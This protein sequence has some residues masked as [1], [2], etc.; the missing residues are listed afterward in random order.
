[1]AFQQFVIS[2]VNPNNAV[3]GGGCIC[4]SNEQVDCKPPYVVFYGNSMADMQSPH[5]VLCKA[6]L[7]RAQER[8][9]T[10][11][12]LVVGEVEDE[13]VAME[14]RAARNPGP[15]TSSIREDDTL[16]DPDAPLI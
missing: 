9:E 8:I 15:T 13:R 11:D 16:P 3:G 10:E 6:C 12:A 7:D 2:Q 14:K 5:A 4:D 1:M